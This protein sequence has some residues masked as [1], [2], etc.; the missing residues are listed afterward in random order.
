M[1]INITLA[2]IIEDERL[3]YLEKTPEE[4]VQNYCDKKGYLI[5]DSYVDDMLLIND[6]KQGRV[7]PT[8]II[9]FGT[10]EDY[11]ELDNLCSKFNIDFESIHLDYHYPED[12]L[13]D[14]YE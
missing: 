14:A 12:I 13:G 6:I 10:Y 7:S 2:H 11:P 5:S 3:L 9:F 4:M 1:M 8:C